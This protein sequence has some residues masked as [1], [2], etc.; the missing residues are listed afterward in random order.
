MDLLALRKPYIKNTENTEN[1]LV[2]HIW[3]ENQN[4]GATLKTTLR[5]KVNSR[6]D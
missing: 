3:H 5:L 2:I 6:I 1:S 4:T